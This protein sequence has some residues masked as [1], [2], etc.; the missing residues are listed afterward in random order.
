[1]VDGSGLMF[2]LPLV[3]FPF[4]LVLQEMS[5]MALF[6]E[7]FQAFFI[8]LSGP[9]LEGDCGGDFTALCLDP[10]TFFPLSF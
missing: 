4:P 2:M 6:N 7:A 5:S 3:A 8:F 10:V 1:M 9:V